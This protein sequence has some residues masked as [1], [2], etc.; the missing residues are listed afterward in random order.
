MALHHVNFHTVYSKPVFED[1]ARDG[2]MRACLP[3]VLHYHQIICLAWEIMPA[4]VHMIVE[5]FPDLSLSTIM[6]HVKGDTSRASFRAY[7]GLREDLL[8][9]HLWAK[10]YYAVAITTH[11]QFL[12]VLR[13]VR[14]N[15]TRAGLESG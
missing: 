12:T 2:M 9:G 13:Y 8:G 6:K 3:G 1:E 15:R 5:D 4:H 14:T 10:G 11:A 7:P